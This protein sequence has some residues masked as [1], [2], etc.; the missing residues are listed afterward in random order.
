MPDH[1]HLSVSTLS[2][3][4]PAQLVGKIKG[5]ASSRVSA[6]FPELKRR[7]QI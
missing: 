1:V 3:F 5:A 6:R 2:R 4:S 7:V